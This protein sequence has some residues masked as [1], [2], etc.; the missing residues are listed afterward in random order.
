MKLQ[1]KGQA[2]RI[3]EINKLMVDLEYFGYLAIGGGEY[4]HTVFSHKKNGELWVL[5][6][7]GFKADGTWND[8]EKFVGNFHESH[9]KSIVLAGQEVKDIELQKPIK[10]EVV[11]HGSKGISE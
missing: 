4:E 7:N 9:K 10:V 1:S 6:P 11:I 2:E 5:S 8:L 3:N